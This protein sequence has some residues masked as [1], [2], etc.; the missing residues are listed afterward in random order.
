[1]RILYI[2]G[3]F[4]ALFLSGWAFLAAFGVAPDVDMPQWILGLVF[5]LCAV[6][7]FEKAAGPG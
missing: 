7:F 1:M 6:S 5:L 4:C 3:G 2:A